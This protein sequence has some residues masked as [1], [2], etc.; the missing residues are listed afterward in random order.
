MASVVKDKSSG[1]PQSA[2]ADVYVRLVSAAALLLVFV[3]ISYLSVVNGAPYDDEI[4]NINA[5]TKYGLKDLIQFINSTDVHPPGS[6]VINKILLDVFG[7]WN[8]VKTAGGVF[9]ALGLAVFLFFA[10]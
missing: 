5:V 3:T 8:A 1:D 2:A 9:N 10:G 4:F 7:S 6:Y